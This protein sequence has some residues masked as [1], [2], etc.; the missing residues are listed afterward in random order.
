[1]KFKNYVRLLIN[2]VVAVSLCMFVFSCGGGGDSD[3][4]GASGQSGTIT[5]STDAPIDG[6]SG[7]YTLPADGS[8]AAVIYAVIKD[9]SGNPVRHY[10][11]VV[12]TTNLGHFRNGS[13]TYTMQTQPPL[14]KDGFPDTDAAP[15]GLADVQFIAGTT[16]GSAKITVTSNGV[17][18]SVYIT[19]SGATG[20]MPVGEAFSLSA[21]YLNISGW[22]MYS[23][24]DTITASAADINGNA[25]I[26]GTIIYFKTYNTGGYVEPASAGTGSG[27]A[28]SILYSTANPA[29]SAGFLMLTG[30]T[31]GDATTRVT[32]IA[33][34]PYPDQHIMYAGTNGG[35]VYKSTNYG[36]T[37][38][39]VSRSSQNPRRGQ[40]LIDPYVK[41]QNGIA[42][43]PD[44]H[45]VVYVGTGYLGKGNVFRS[46]DGAMNW[47]SNNVEQWN[48]LYETTAAVLSVVADGDDNSST[49][50]PYVWI[51][52]EGRGP[53]YAA[54]GKS[55]QP[56]GGTATSPVFSGTGNGT[57]SH[58]V[59]SYSSKSE[60]WTTTCA[61]STSA[62]SSPSFSGTGNGGMSAVTTSASTV[63]ETWSV[64]Y[65]ALV[66][67]ITQTGTG[68]GSLR[69]VA[70]TKPN[71]AVET[72]TLTCTSAE[73]TISAVTGTAAANGAL[74][75]IAVTGA[76]AAQTQTFTLTCTTAGGSGVGI[77]S[78]RGNKLGDYAGVATVDTTYGPT[79]GL[80]FKINAGT[81]NYVVGETFVFTVTVGG[82]FSVL[83]DAVGYYPEAS[84]GETYNEDGLTFLI[85]M[86]STAFVVDDTFTFTITTDWHVAG[87]VSG[88]QTNTVTVGTL[89]TSDGSEVS[90]TIWEGTIDYAVGDTFTFRTTGGLTYWTVVGTVSG[91][92]TKLAFANQGYYSDGREVYFEIT[93]G[94]TPFEISD[95]FTFA[96]TANKVNHGWTVWDMVRVPDTH[97]ATAILYAGTATGVYKTTNGSRTWSSAGF[98]TGD[99]ILALELYPT[100]TGGATD[101]IYAGTQNA[102][103]WASPDGGTTWTQYVTGIDSGYGATIKDLLVDPDNHRLYAVTYKGP[104]GSATGSV[105]MHT[106]NTN[107]TMTADPWVKANTGMSGTSL[108]ALGSDMPSSPTALFVGGEG[109]NLYKATSGLDTGNPS[110]YESKGD[111]SN[112][113]MARMPVL[114]SGECFMTIYRTDYGNGYSYFE[115]Y[116][117]DENGNPPLKGSI[118]TAVAA[119]RSGLE[120]APP[121]LTYWDVTY[122]ECYTTPHGD[123]IH[124]TFRDP[125]DGATNDPYFVSANGNSYESV[126]FT[127]TPTCEVEAPGCSGSNQTWTY[128]LHT[129]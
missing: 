79:N 119:P 97:G 43:D 104:V 65:R 20:N 16:P 105:Y 4:G 93:E 28:I 100:A 1:M 47:N 11:E 69:N 68:D 66:G 40:N 52:T 80:T 116:I 71:A 39:T 82:T 46:L 34:T 63:T 21:A 88:P 24:E 14:G 111:I 96:V 114:F 12:F 123:F 121:E 53:L 32:S 51:G 59:L 112:L 56:S 127:F 38:E 94:T 49:D 31:E 77:F 113:I 33:T 128:A 15:T 25:V 35:G 124:G 110:W 83:S 85:N 122:P 62:A 17:T 55:F 103:V 101:I 29:P 6:E 9:S 72:W 118:F 26:D 41:G 73:P 102:G 109:I 58:P 23:L 67:D 54:D 36:D 129:P 81:A 98:F 117:E 106:L 37:W 107:G 95:A 50:Y 27:K 89:Y 18:Q 115:I 48:G 78:V 10:T 45:N 74:T 61:G 87:T 99:Y 84:V 70:M 126:T 75:G 42:V 86:G 22:W 108:Y 90:F 3:S 5:L 91:I 8:S 92:Q 64:I 7:L 30:E 57:M 44:N 13:T 60:T 2:A 19:L 120:P 76:S 125:S